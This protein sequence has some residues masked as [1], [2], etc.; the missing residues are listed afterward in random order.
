MDQDNNKQDIQEQTNVIQQERRRLERKQAN[1]ISITPAPQHTPQDELTKKQSRHELANQKIDNT[2]GKTINT[3]TNETQE[4]II[5]KNT[6]KENELPRIN[7][8]QTN[9]QKSVTSSTTSQEY[10]TPPLS[11]NS[12]ISDINTEDL[13]KLN[14]TR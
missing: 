1:L 8:L 9:T 4:P 7:I 6:A 11:P 2:N 10:C 12:H 13:E 3:I 5:H 14:E